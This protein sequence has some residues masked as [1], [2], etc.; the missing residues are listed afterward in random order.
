MKIGLNLPVMVP[1]WTR[2]SLHEWCER[3]DRGPYATLAIGERITF[4]N[5]EIMVTAGAAV[6]LTERVKIALTVVVLPMHREL[7]IAKQ[8][9]TLDVFSRGRLI[10]GL[11]VGA[12][13]ED[14][15][16]LGAD[17]DNK[18]LGKLE[19]QVARMRQAWRGEPVV[20]GALRPIEPL[21]IQPGGPELLAGSLFP[22]SIRR[23]AGWA[24]GLCGFS[25]GPSMA[26]VDLAWQSARAA[27]AERGRPEPRL[28]TSFFFALGKQPRAQ[29]EEFLGR[30]L[31]FFGPEAAQQLASTVRT[32]SPSAVRT[33]LQELKDLGTDE[34]ML[35]PTTLDPDEIDRLAD[36]VVS[37]R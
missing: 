32:D 9:A 23:A 12:R 18:R 3:I 2:G 21:P 25:F 17:F 36:V 5:P 20:E 11:G 22:Q 16:A 29:L 37:L 8:A 19:R 15:N 4:P 13:V 28:T 1:G 27:W 10:L 34:V 30:Y 7:L 35:V 14:Y 26:E 31:N 33:A 6:A 24:D